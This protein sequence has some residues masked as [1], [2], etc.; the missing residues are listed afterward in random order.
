LLE[1][2]GSIPETGRKISCRGF[3]FEIT[4]ADNRRIKQVK[5]TKKPV[6]E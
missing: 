4:D 1:L 2:E 5:A 3:I 6:N